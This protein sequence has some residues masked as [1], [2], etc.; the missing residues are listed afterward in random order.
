MF[1]TGQILFEFTVDSSR[2]VFI[3][4]K[5]IIKRDGKEVEFQPK[6]I[7]QAIFKAMLSVGNG[8][9]EDAEQFTAK[10]VS[11]LDAQGRVPTV[12]DV[13]DIVIKVLLEDNIGGKQF[14]NVAESYILYRDNRRRIREEKKRLSEKPVSASQSQQLLVEEPRVDLRLRPSTVTNRRG[15]RVPI[16]IG[17]IRKVVNEACDGLSGVDPLALELDSQIHFYEGIST[18]AIQETLIRV[19]N[20]KTSVKEP[21]WTYVAARLLLHDLYEEAAKNRNYSGRYG[22]F[23]D[24]VKLLTD[25]GRYDPAVISNYSRAELEELG[26]YIKPERDRLFNYAGLKHLSD[27]YAIR[28]INN[29]VLE[30]PQEV[31]MG[32]SVFLALAEKSEDRILWAKKFYDVLSNLYITMATPTLANARRVNGQLSSCFIDTPEDSLQSIFDGLTTFA[33]VSQNGGGMGVYIGKLRSLGSTIRGYRGAGS[34]IVPWVRLYND[35]AVS[36]NQLGQRAGA[37][38][39]WLDIWHKDIMDFLDLKTNNGDERRKAY[40][41]FPGVCI[42]DRFYR[43]V[44][45]DGT[46]YLMDPHEIRSVK[47]WSLEDSWGEEW[48]KRYDECIS[49]ERIDKKSMPALEVFGMILRSL[50][51]TGGPF[52]FNRDTVNRMNPN[53]H[54]G[55]IYSSNLCTEICQNQSPTAMVRET[56]SGDTISREYRPGDLVVCNLSSINLGRTNSFEK[57]RE[58]I[59]VQVRMLDNVITMNTLPLE[60]ARITNSR[61]RAIG[62]GISGYHQH[63][64]EKGIDWESEEHFTYADRLFEEINYIAIKSDMELSKERGHYPLFKGSDWE[65]GE[66]FRLRGYDDDRWKDLAKDVSVHGLRNGYIMAIAPTGSTSVIAGSTAGID[67]VFKQVFIEEKKGFIIKQIVPNLD[68]KTAQYYKSAHNID[69]MW[70]IKAAAARQR[71]LDQSQSM[72]IYATSDMDE[73]YLLKVYFQ[74]WKLGVKTIYYFRNFT[75]NEDVKEEEVCESCQA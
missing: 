20:E 47:G 27:R 58:V 53:K 6:K 45:K 66:Y 64:A 29:E 34:G 32:I 71:H 37:V 43:E 33:K 21:N 9:I 42:P 51:E 17:K 67:P 46:W 40:D 61:Y 73:Q 74:A 60:Q 70:S 8:D 50:Y 10:V 31:F 24:L 44:E 15:E 75:L 68:S 38:S 25:L 3:V 41:V 36:V 16:D 69:Q 2:G 1:L 39:I 56:Q 59:P 28:G 63:L 55:M 26:S 49:D 14:S 30:L 7:T 4:I 72:N 57:L 35:T 48:E 52:I 23:Y 13:Q 65:T 12:E 62:I 11:L 22:S 54:A 5:K 19:A 18:R